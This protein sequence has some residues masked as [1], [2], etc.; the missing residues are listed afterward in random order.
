MFAHPGRLEAQ[1]FR[2]AGVSRQVLAPAL[3]QKSTKFHHRFSFQKARL[4][5]APL[6]S[7]RTAPS[8][9]EDGRPHGG[10]IV[11]HLKKERNRA[12][13]PCAV[14]TLVIALTSIF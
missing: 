10:P 6:R 3:P 9:I 11:R 7:L 4:K 5:P 2:Q 12:S 14:T 13:R 1:F 8:N